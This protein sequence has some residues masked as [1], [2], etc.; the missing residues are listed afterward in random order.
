MPSGRSRPT[1]RHGRRCWARGPGWRRRGSGSK[2]IA[3]DTGAAEAAV[4]QAQADLQTARLNLGY[5]EIRAPIDGYV[6]NRAA[7]VGAY[8]TPGTYLL[9]IS[10]AHGLWVDA[11]FK[12]DQLAGMRPG[13]QATVV[14]DVLPGHVLHGHVLSLAPATGAIFSVIPPENATGNFT[15]IVQRVPVRIALDGAD[16]TLG[17]LR[18]GLSTTV[19]VDTRADGTRAVDARADAKAAP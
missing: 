2:V 18:P 17:T 11:N 12:E 19:S 8:V 15:K 9:S 16:A 7:Q 14:A 4:A 1:R 13:Q 3:A 10:P 6:G 5:T